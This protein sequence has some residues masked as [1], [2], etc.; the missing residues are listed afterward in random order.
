MIGLACVVVAGGMNVV[1]AARF[2]GGKARSKKRRVRFAVLTASV[3]VAGLACMVASLA[4][5]LALSLS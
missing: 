2:S 3:A 1:T 4:L 5:A